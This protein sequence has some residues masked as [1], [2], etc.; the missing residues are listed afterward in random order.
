MIKS[1]LGL[2]AFVFLMPAAVQNLPV[3]ADDEAP[4]IQV[5]LLLDT[6]NSMD[7]LIDQAKSQLWKMVNELAT[8]RKNGQAPSIEIALYEYGNDGLPGAEGHIRQ[9][10]PLTADLDLVSEKLFGLSTN[11]GSEYCGYVIN[12]AVKQLGWSDQN[13]DLKI[14]IIAGNEPFDQGPEAYKEACRD[15]IKQGIIVNTI[16]CGNYDEGVSSYWKDGA[17]LADGKYFNI[18]LN[19]QVVHIPTPF[20]DRILELNRKLNDTYIG[21][22]RQGRQRVEMQAEQ[23]ANA[24]TYG[25]ANAAERASFKAKESYKNTSWDLVDAVEEDEKALDKLSKDDLPEEMKNMNKEEQKKFVEKKSKERDDIR[26]EILDLEQQANKFR[27]EK[28]REMAESGDN[29]LDKVMSKAMQEQ[30][31]KKGFNK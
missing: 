7:G 24:A 2:F 1:F 4:N 20:D 5:A 18:D 23:D 9:V 21:Y 16:F 6:S 10:T 25:A 28:R 11:G 22:G 27:D 29:T 17:G 31:Q 12:R 14:I 15:A 3:A 13:D 8:T 30:A 26:K 19:Q